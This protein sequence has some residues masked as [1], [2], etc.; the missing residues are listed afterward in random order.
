MNLFFYISLGYHRGIIARFVRL[1][2]FWIIKCC[3]ISGPVSSTE[4]TRF[5]RATRI[6]TRKWNCVSKWRSLWPAGLW[7]ESIVL[8][9]SNILYVK[10]ESLVGR[11]IL[12]YP[13]LFLYSLRLK[14]LP[15][16]TFDTIIL[17]RRVC[18]KGVVIQLIR[19]GYPFAW[20][21]A[22]GQPLLSGEG[23]SNGR[24]SV[25]LQRSH[26]KMN[27]SPPHWQIRLT[28]HAN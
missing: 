24:G 21:T 22:T 28:S 16:A 18:E 3:C 4:R 10:V 20:P 1:V 17:Y 26:F 23:A 7:S 13:S 14:L 27:F 8:R 5:F 11:S 25:L 12:H 2:A 15:E 6:Q 9:C 19:R